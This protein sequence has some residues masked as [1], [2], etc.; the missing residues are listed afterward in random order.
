MA[1]FGLHQVDPGVLHQVPEIVPIRL[2]Q[3]L[4]RG[5]VD[6]HTGDFGGVEIKRRQDVE[7]AAHADR[8]HAGMAH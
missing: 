1:A 3:Y 5:C 8:R 4:D 7:T 2:L 6:F